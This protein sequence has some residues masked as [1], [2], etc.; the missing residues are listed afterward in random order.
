MNRDSIVRGLAVLAAIVLALFVAYSIVWIML[1]SSRK[2]LRTEGAETATLDVNAEL[3]S[4]IDSLEVAWQNIQN[5]KFTISQDPLYL[6]RVVKDFKFAQAGY[7]ETEEEQT[8]RLTATVIDDNPK[9]IIKYNGKSYVVQV[10][11]WLEKA[12]RIV[13][14][15]ERQVVLEGAGG[16]RVLYNKPVQELEKMQEESDYSN[17]ESTTENY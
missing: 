1:S 16:R 11:G 9:A 15:E 13:S 3:K 8:I 2:E 17:N 7:K 5:H 14:I 10:G 6:G 12:Y 4:T